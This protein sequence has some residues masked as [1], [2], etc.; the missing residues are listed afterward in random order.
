M[1]DNRALYGRHQII[2]N[3]QFYVA[4]QEN[5]GTPPATLRTD[6]LTFEGSTWCI[7]NNLTLASTNCGITVKSYTPRTDAVGVDRSLGMGISVNASRT[8]TLAYPFFGTGTVVKAGD[9]ELRLTDTFAGFGGTMRLAKGALTLGP[10]PARLK[11]LDCLGGTLLLDM[12]AATPDVPRLTV[13]ETLL[14]TN[15]AR[16]GVGVA[17][18]AVAAQTALPLVRAPGTTLSTMLRGNRFALQETGG[19]KGTLAVT[20]GTDGTETLFFT[21]TNAVTEANKL[22]L[23][24]RA[25]I[26]TRTQAAAGRPHPRLFAD[27]A[28][29]RALR[30]GPALGGADRVQAR[31]ERAASPR[32]EPDRALPHCDP[33]DVLPPLR[34]QASP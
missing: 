34:E 22:P 19:V 26:V 21:A 5:L 30:D 25:D 18:T 24:P 33:C 28:G 6:Y 12:S 32:R 4:R 13:T 9:G 14:A 29:F 10:R 2:G 17:R 7:T 11:T 8:A 1:G 20:A 23:V 31:R 3:G 15:G 27:A 16:I